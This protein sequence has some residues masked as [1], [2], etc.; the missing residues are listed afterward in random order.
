A[1]HGGWTGASHRDR[2]LLAMALHASFGGG[3]DIPKPILE[4]ISPEDRA[5]AKSWGLAIRLAQRLSGG[6]AEALQ[7]SQLVRQADKLVL[8]IAPSHAVL[9]SDQVQRRLKSLAG[10]LGARFAVEIKDLV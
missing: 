9:A 8:T 1:L 7:H 6:T 3:E 4:L 10:H 5:M 2:A